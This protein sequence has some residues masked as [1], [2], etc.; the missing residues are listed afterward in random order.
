MVLNG[1]TDAPDSPGHG[2]NFDF[3]KV[4]KYTVWWLIKI[5]IL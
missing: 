1:Y 2:I 5:N 4:K 3:E